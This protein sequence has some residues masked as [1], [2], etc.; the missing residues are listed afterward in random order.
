MS[1]R[2][3]G[4][5]KPLKVSELN[6]PKKEKKEDDED[7]AAFKERKKAE[8]AALKE[9]REKGASLSLLQIPKC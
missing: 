3:G 1:G 8:A 7:D 9:A 4:K 5:L 2:A 6:A